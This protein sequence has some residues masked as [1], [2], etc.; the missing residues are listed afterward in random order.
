MPGY[1]GVSDLLEVGLKVLVDALHR[2][3]EAEEASSGC[4]GVNEAANRLLETEVRLGFSAS[5]SQLARVLTL[6]RGFCRLS[7]SALQQCLAMNV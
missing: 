6:P 7:A 5:R 4:H 2:E 1:D 3:F